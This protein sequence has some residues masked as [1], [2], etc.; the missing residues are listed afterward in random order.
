MNTI[1]T[2][3]QSAHNTASSS[4]I[5]RRGRLGWRAVAGSVALMGV[6]MTSLGVA[7]FTQE[8]PKAHIEVIEMPAAPNAPITAEDMSAHI[9]VGAN[10][11]VEQPAVLQK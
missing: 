6:G 4:M 8:V 1:N 10:A 2:T 3:E 11:G 5:E 9:G 7:T